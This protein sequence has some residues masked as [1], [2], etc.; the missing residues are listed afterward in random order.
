MGDWLTH[1]T[2]L[3]YEALTGVR[4]VHHLTPP[5]VTL[6]RRSNFPQRIDEKADEQEAL[7]PAQAS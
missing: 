7:E 1:R 5:P 3:S 6:R 4:P 2:G